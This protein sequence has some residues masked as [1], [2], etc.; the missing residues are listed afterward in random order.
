MAREKG[1]GEREGVVEE[2]GRIAKESERE[3]ERG[4]ITVERKRGR[5]RERIRGDK[6]DQ[7]SGEG[8][9][10]YL[11]YHI[12]VKAESVNMENVEVV[13]DDAVAGRVLR[14]F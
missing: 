9:V 8:E 6:G 12:F 7:G 2:I 14:V 11:M 13:T 5:K 1:S 4:F 10:C 3:R